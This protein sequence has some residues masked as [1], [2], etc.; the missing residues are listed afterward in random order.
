MLA[1]DLGLGKVLGWHFWCE[2]LEQ[3]LAKPDSRGGLGAGS[4]Y[5]SRGVW[6]LSALIQ[7]NDLCEQISAIPMVISGGGTCPLPRGVAA[8]GMAL[9]FLC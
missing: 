1:P 7:L 4:T 2:L 3:D 6:M 5:K 8:E 9:S